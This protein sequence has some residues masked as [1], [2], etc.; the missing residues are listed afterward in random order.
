MPPVTKKMKQSVIHAEDHDIVAM[1]EPKQITEFLV[2][3]HNLHEGLFDLVLGFQVAVGSV[4]PG[5]SSVMPGAV[6]GVKHIGL[7]KVEKKSATTV[8]AA[9]VN[10][11]PK[12]HVVKK[13][14]A[15]KKAPAKK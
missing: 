2:K 6:I 5:P 1:Y 4:G 15:T 10:P 9:K 13:P 11:A 7:V 8:N 3:L 14:A 12:K